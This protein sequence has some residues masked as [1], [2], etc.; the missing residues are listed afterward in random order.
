I[1]ALLPYP[2]NGYETAAG[3]KGFSA[4]AAIIREQ[5]D[6]VREARSRTVTLDTGERDTMR[7]MIEIA[8]DCTSDN[9]DGDG[10]KAVSTAS[11]LSAKRF[12]EALP[13]GMQSPEV[14]V[15]PDGEMVFEWTSG[16]QHAFSI[17]FG[18]GG[19]LTYAG[20]FGP[21]TTHG[22]EYISYGLPRE[23]VAKIQRASAAR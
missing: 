10:A 3:S 20:L 8:L 1:T 19:K 2:G 13:P 6:G 9:W 22:V 5:I 17:S 7:R 15:D 4:E 11:F 18:A 14:S 23:L 12:L 21:S 16:P